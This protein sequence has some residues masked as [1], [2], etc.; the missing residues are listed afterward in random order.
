MY[1]IIFTV[2]KMQLTLSSLKR[3]NRS[4]RLMKHGESGLMRKVLITCFY[5]YM[6]LFNFNLFALTEI[7]SVAC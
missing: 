1:N 3:V 5:M 6:F 4:W 2:L 7:K